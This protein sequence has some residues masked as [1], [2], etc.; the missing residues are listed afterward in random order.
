MPLRFGG[1]SH[2][3]QSARSVEVRPWADAVLTRYQV[4]CRARSPSERFRSGPCA[5]FIRSRLCSTDVVRD[6]GADCVSPSM[7]LR[8]AQSG[9]SGLLRPAFCL[10]AS[11]QI[12]ASWSFGPSCDRL[13]AQSVLHVCPRELTSAAC[14][15][16][17]DA[18]RFPSVRANHSV[19][20][21]AEGTRSGPSTTGLSTETCT[22]GIDLR[23]VP[24][25]LSLTRH[26]S[27]RRAVN[28][29]LNA[30]EPLAC[31][32]CAMVSDR[33]EARAGACNT[34][35]YIVEG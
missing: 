26:V 34:S 19:T 17:S 20:P 6:V 7:R 27:P 8:D 22:S 30:R 18:T 15:P 21:A 32:G 24:K 9:R 23:Q 4:R 10:P 12:R 11:F 28:R 33:A 1:K 31:I 25:Q 13:V 35:S 5:H 14:A 3:A 29:R 2:F 16:S